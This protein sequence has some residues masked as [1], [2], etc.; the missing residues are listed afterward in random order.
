MKY[1]QGD[2]VVLL[3]EKENLTW[4]PGTV[5][6]DHD[7]NQIQ[8]PDVFPK[9]TIGYVLVPLNDTCTIDVFLNGVDMEEHL[10]VVSAG[11]DEIA[12]A[13][14]TADEA[15]AEWISRNSTGGA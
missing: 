10:G 1:A 6:E 11:H 15:R 12:P 7:G 4:P 14:Q 3:A 2:R 8:V 5:I 13:E 9:G